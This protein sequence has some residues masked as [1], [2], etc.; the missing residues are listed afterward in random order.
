MR[1]RIGHDLKR[2]AV[3]LLVLGLAWRTV[4][5]AMN[6]SLSSDEA[7]IAVHL[8]DRDFAGL[9]APLGYAQVAPVGFLWTELATARLLGF[10]ETALRLPAWIQNLA[11][12]GLFW[13]FARRVLDRR[14]ALLAVGIFASSYYVVRHGAEVK[15]YAGDVLLALGVIWLAGRILENEQALGPKIGLTLLAAAGVWVSYPAVFVAAGAGA[16][17]S[18]GA[19]RSR[20]RR[21]LLFIAVYGLVLM[22]SFFLVYLWIDRYQAR[23]VPWWMADYWRDAFPPVKQPLR[24]LWWL[25][26]IHAGVM[27]AYPVGAAHFGSALTLVCVVTGAVGMARSRR[28]LLLLLLSPLPFAFVAAALERYPYG[29]AIRT[30]LYMAP[31]FCLL[32]GAGLVTL[33]KATLSRRGAVRGVRVAAGVLAVIAA[34]GI[35]LDV[36]R[37]YKEIGDHENRRILRLVCARCEPGDEWAVVTGEAEARFRFYLSRFSPVPVRWEAQPADLSRPGPT[38]IRLIAYTYRDRMLP[39]ELLDACREALTVRQG[40]WRHEGFPLED[41]I[42]HVYEFG[43]SPSSTGPQRIGGIR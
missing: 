25:I 9:T 35:A 42:I 26:D 13:S 15:P 8:L 34:A 5:L 2:W 23:D 39:K 36:T 22:A 38:R 21:A 4:R 33:L 27:L 41:G 24:L 31:S 3:V 19:L 20:S 43:P 17:L 7:S 40:P 28:D 1:Q 29:D 10:T 37:P 6:F 32:A 30:S 16:V 11:A 14:R 12:L 18:W